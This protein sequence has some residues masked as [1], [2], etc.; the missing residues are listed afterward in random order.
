MAA[1]FRSSRIALALACALLPLQQLAASEDRQREARPSLALMGSVPIFWG[2][3]Q[4]LGEIVEGSAPAHWARGLIEADHNLDPLD[5]LTPEKLAG[6]DYLLMAQPRA[7][8]PSE[9]V[10]LD[11]WVRAGGRLL[12][13]A[14]PMMTGESRFALGDR[15]RPMDVALLSPILAHWGLEMEFDEAQEE[16]VREASSYYGY[17]LPVNLAGRFVRKG[18]ECMPRG[19]DEMMARCALGQ[20]RA[21]IVA[22]AAI[23]DLAG[24]HPGAEAALRGLL[25]DVFGDYGDSAGNVAWRMA[26]YNRTHAVLPPSAPDPAAA[27]APPPPRDP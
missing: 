8:A 14:D 10:A 1:L 27:E 15:R 16:G 3:P 9:N 7:L 6:H 18:N 13:F 2:E 24:P 12:L 22:D 5:F 21:L 17:D 20:G 23:L 25:Q 11:E 26:F 4:S 19:E